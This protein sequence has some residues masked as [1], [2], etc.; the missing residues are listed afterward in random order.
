KKRERVIH[1]LI[2]RVSTKGCLA[3]RFPGN[4]VLVDRFKRCFSRHFQYE[5]PSITLLVRRKIPGADEHLVESRRVDDA[6]RRSGRRT[7]AMG[8][9]APSRGSL[10][11]DPANDVMRLQIAP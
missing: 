2:D 9:V 1:G 7:D 4:V 5:A 8:V 3:I 6:L 10:A 11:R